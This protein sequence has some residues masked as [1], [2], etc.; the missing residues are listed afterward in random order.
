M[1]LLKKFENPLYGN[2]FHYYHLEQRL[3]L[4]HLPEFA[5]KLNEHGLSPTKFQIS[6]DNSGFDGYFRT[7]PS[8]KEFLM[9]CPDN[10]DEIY[11]ND[12]GVDVVFSGTKYSLTLKLPSTLTIMLEKGCLEDAFVTT[13]S[14]IIDSLNQ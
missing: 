13:I 3:N 14:N 8:I 10:N 1:K 9:Y 2:V 11:I 12:F 7:F 5:K 4:L 6:N